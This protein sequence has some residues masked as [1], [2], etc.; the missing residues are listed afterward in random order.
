MMVATSK[1]SGTPAVFEIKSAHLPLAAVLIKQFDFAALVQQWQA[2][3]ESTPDFFNQDPFVVDLTQITDAI[4]PQ[5]FEDFLKFLQAANVHPMAVR[6]KNQ[7]HLMLAKQWGLLVSDDI[8]LQ[9][10]SHIQAQQV[11]QAET[12]APVQAAAA[13]EF[14]PTMVIDKPLRS[15][16][17]IYARHADLIVL[18]AVNPGAE[19]IADGHIHVYAPLRGKAIAGAKGKQDAKIFTSCLEAELLSIAGVYRTSETPFAKD[20]LG[21]SVIIKLSADDGNEKIV[22]QAV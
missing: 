6:S 20:I 19:I 21:K 15:G 1:A 18:A 17:Q 22:I 12:A 10:I 3:F 7:Q 9:K 4:E 14:M 5:Q 8:V 16:Q 13:P 11:Q 2:Q